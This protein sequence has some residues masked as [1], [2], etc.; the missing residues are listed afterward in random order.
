MSNI[1]D[2]KKCPLCGKD[3]NC[4]VDSENPCWCTNLEIPTQLIA[5]LPLHLQGK[6]CICMSCVISCGE[7]ATVKID[8]ISS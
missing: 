6:S 3:N 8:A 4:M 2:E 1:V 5:L 7:D